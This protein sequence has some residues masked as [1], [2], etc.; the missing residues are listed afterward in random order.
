MAM[1]TRKP[2]KLLATATQ[3]RPAIHEWTVPATLRQPVVDLPADEGS[4]DDD[5]GLGKRA[6]EYLLRHIGLG[7]ADLVQQVVGLVGNQERVSQDEHESARESPGKVGAL[8]RIDIKRA[9]EFPQRPLRLVLP[10]PPAIIQGDREKEDKKAADR[11]RG[12]EHGEQAAGEQF[13]QERAAHRCDGRADAQDTGDQATLDGRDLVGQH[14]HHGGQKRVEEQLGDT[15]SGKDDRDA[16]CQRDNQ[17]TKR[18]AHQADNHPWPP[19][20]QRRRGTVAHPAEERVTDHGQQGAD[21]A[22]SAKLLGACLIPTSEFT[23]KARVTSTGAGTGGTCSG[24]P[25]CTAR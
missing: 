15:P 19:H 9:D 6:Q 5:G 24:T 21:P 4:D 12:Q 14:R 22:T 16:G 3:Q 20:A 1:P 2:L 13:N 10:G 23:F 18:T 8:P 7:G 25:A 11:A 17:D